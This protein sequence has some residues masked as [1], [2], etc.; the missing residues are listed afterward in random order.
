MRRIPLSFGPLSFGLVAI[1]LLGVVACQAGGTLPGSPPRGAPVRSA[2]A[3]ARAALAGGGN[4]PGRVG[5]APA[6]TGCGTGPARRAFAEEIGAD[7]RVTWQVRLPTDPTQSGV[8]V[9]PVVTG[10]TAVFAEENAVYALR[11]ADGHQLWK[12]VFPLAGTD[13]VS[14]MVY[15]MWRWRGSVIVLAGQVTSH[16]RLVSLDSATGAVKWTLPLGKRGLIGTLA[17]TGDGGIAMIRSGGTLA[18]ADLTTGRI[19]W[20]RTAVNSEGPVAVDGVVIAAVPGKILGFSSRTGA[21]LWTRTGTPEQAALLVSAGRVFVFDDDQ[22]V[23]PP[24][25]LWPATALAPATGRTLWRTGTGTFVY[26]QS[27][28]PSGVAVTTSG[29]KLLLI[30]AASGH[31]RLSV[32]DRDSQLPL[33]TGT[34][35]L[36]ADGSAASGPTTLVDVRSASGSVRWSAPAPADSSGQVSRFG[37]YAVM[38][39]DPSTPGKPGRLAAFTLSTGKRAWTTAIPTLLQVPLVAAGADLLAQPTDPGYACAT[40]GYASLR[41]TACHLV[42]VPVRRDAGGRERH[43]RVAGRVQEALGPQVVVAHLIA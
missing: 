26:S 34:D 32:R 18:V 29:R 7:G 12:Q 6:S 20:Q 17:L 42:L 41:R 23:Y 24:V 27:A 9:Q 22:A 2:A 13:P 16:A 38:A 33:D 39:V 19:R 31:V 25:P 36:Y 1:G 14:G 4:A 21:P 11:A 28:G 3:P 37:A 8:A 30:G 15:G 43:Q 40:A 5:A 10:A 35:L